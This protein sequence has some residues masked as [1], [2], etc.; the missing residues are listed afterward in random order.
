[1]A[2]Q[3][4]N[5]DVIE[6]PMGPVTLPAARYP[7]R[8]PVEGSVVLPK[9]FRKDEKT[10]A[11]QA[12]TIWERDVKIPMRDGTILRADIFRPVDSDTNK[13]PVLLVWSPYGKSGTGFFDVG[14][15]PGRVGVAQT[16]LSGLESFEAPD[17]AEWIQHGYAVANVNARGILVSGGNHRWHGTAEGRDGYDTIEFMGSLPWTNGH[18]ALIG[19]S[20]L[21]TSQ[22]FI[23]AERPP[24]LS[25]IL[26]LEGLSDVYRETICRGGVP[27]KPFW[28]YLM[29]HL[30]GENLQEDVIS[31]IEK[32]PLMNEYWED[33]RARADLI[34]V[35]AY[36]LA[37]MS[38]GLHTV[39]SI[40]CYEDI[41]HEKKWLR[42][43]PT[44]EWHDLYQSE[45]IADLKKFLDFYT[46]G[47]RNDWEETPRVRLSILRFNQSPLI[48][49]PF[50]TWPIPQTQYQ[51]LHLSDESRLVPD[52]Q[53]V[54]AGAVTFQGDIRA[55]QTDQDPEEVQFRFTFKTKTTLI[56]PAKLTVWMSCPDH[57]DF[58]VF[59]QLRKADSTGQILQ[60][61]NIPLRE[62]GYSSP[63]EVESVN[64][65]K[66]LGPTG[67]LRASH[68][69]LDPVLSKP[70]WPAH[71][72]TR[73]QR[74]QAGEAVELQIGLWPSAIQFEESEQ[75]VLKI[76]GHHMTLAEFVP[77]RG[78]FKSG[79]RGR[80]TVHWG[81]RFNSHLEI[82]VVPV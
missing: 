79:N 76:A 15:I 18:V 34:N 1:M 21:A 67:V 72:H 41:P 12:A 65:L 52:A 4:G 22:W 50:S 40:R 70:H 49:M 71:V 66:Y 54:N 29:N 57:D 74:V 73:R 75:L 28:S 38:S 23:A 36:I 48:N 42:M 16:M 44:Q 46:K 7:Q 25:C 43:H 59:V 63:E 3:V 14:I 31:M 77:L 55:M 39:G 56:G 47:I 13:V 62:L 35:P 10:R 80:Q 2:Y 60:A 24:H 68:R 8:Y 27:Y 9:G 33:K 20:W 6:R 78:Q 69:E 45:T 19:N 61:L 17:P 58:D 64:V 81:E 82:P 51:T 32:F 5:I 30:F 37:S 26:P 11:F 53:M